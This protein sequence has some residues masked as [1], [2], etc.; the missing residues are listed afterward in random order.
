M[1]KYVFFVWSCIAWLL[2]CTTPERSSCSVDADIDY[3]VGKVRLALSDL[4]SKGCDYTLMPR[5][6]CEE[7]SVWHCRKAIP[8]EWCSGFWPGVLWYAYEATGDSVLKEQAM[9]YTASL[10]YMAWRPIYDH[11]L[12]FILFC[13]MGNG[14]RLTEDPGYKRALLA[15][16]DSLS[17]LFNPAAG[18]IL[19]WPRNVE[20]LGGHNTIMDNMMNLELLFWAAKHGGD[21]HLYDQAV[22][23]A[24]TTMRYHFREDYSCYHVAVYDSLS[25]QFLKGITHQGYSDSSMW[26]RGQS[27][28]IYGYT[29]VYRETGDPTFLDFACK[30]ADVY[31]SRLPEDGVPYWDFD[32]PAI[33][34]APRD[35]SAAC[36]VASALLELQSYCPGEKGAYYLRQ[37]RHM[38]QSLG[39]D[40]YRSRKGK[41]SM[42][43]HSVGH[44]PAGSEVDASI[45]YADYYYIEALTRLKSLSL[46]V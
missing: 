45:I 30:V 4:A 11:D 42:L 15:A 10:D 8:E 29:L 23:H 22:K 41:V 9:R 36:V 40:A 3:C 33:P 5:N 19:S 46:P 17:T 27:W 31:L 7:D 16:A 2:S 12:G 21:S 37:A 39:S 34:D 1:N 35:V 43:D 20:M 38:L 44:R 6:I 28:A 26:A 24:E 18:T 25:G 32:D 13:S 14:W